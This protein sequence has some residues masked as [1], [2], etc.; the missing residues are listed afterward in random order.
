MEESLSWT[1]EELFNLRILQ[2]SSFLMT[3][4][5]ILNTNLFRIIDW[6]E[7]KEEKQATV[8]S[9]KTKQCLG[10]QIHTTIYFTYNF[11]EVHQHTL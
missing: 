5:D 6:K 9:P 1:F 3:E 7:I 8:N 4:N 2:F 10:P 11:S